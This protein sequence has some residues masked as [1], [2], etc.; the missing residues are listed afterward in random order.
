MIAKTS[1]TKKLYNY[2]CFIEDFFKEFNK[3]TDKYT[4]QIRGII[5]S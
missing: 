5:S 3:D 1:R 4:P 2:Y